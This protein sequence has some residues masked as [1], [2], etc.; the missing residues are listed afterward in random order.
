M[1]ES[2]IKERINACSGWLVQKQ[3]GR[4]QY[5][6][7]Y[8]VEGTNGKSDDEDESG[9]PKGSGTRARQGDFA[10]AKVVGLEFLPEKEHEVAFQEVK[11]MRSL[12]H[13]HIVSLRDHFFTEAN[14]ELVIVMEYCD[15]GDLRGEVKKAIT[16]KASG[17]HPGS[18]AHG[19]V[20]TADPG[21][22]LH[23]PAA[24]A[25]PRPQELKHLHDHK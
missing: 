25:S 4:G 9:K 16:G 23:P 18:A 15:Q 5:G 6:T 8:L 17:S 10:V 7:A 20:C 14:L 11:L 3:L 12:R 21:T 24:R 19:V 2:A 22:E 1:G 13:N